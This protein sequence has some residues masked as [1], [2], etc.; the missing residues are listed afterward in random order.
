[1]EAKVPGAE[2]RYS[3]YGDGAARLTGLKGRHIDASTFSI[4]EYLR[5][6]DGG[7]RGV[8]YLQPERHPEAPEMP[9]AREQ[10]V[11]VISSVLHYF[12]VPKG[13]PADRIEKL[14]DLIE[15]AMATDTARE[16]MKKIRVEPTVWRGVALEQR[17]AR[18]ER[19]IASVKTTKTIALP[20]YTA[21]VL[22]AL[23]GLG[24]I[25][26]IQIAREPRTVD[27]SSTAGDRSPQFMAVACM[28]LV[29]LYV[30]VWQWG[31]VDFRL[32]TL[33]FV[34]LCGCVLTRLERRYLPW[35]LAESLLLAFG[36]Y[37]VFT[38]WLGRELGV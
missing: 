25:V 5:Y 33:A 8:A 1:L 37:F 12:W 10:G 35:L 21:Y 28:C 13:T 2:F 27:L 3:Q 19:D 14:A 11:D 16:K 7:L 31:K 32:A 29:A 17:I 6:R 24:L 15:A 30:A 18:V 20:N 34:L 22:S 26:V 23:V 38:W 9:T 4:E 36:I